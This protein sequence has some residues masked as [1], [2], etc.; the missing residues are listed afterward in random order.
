MDLRKIAASVGNGYE[1][2]ARK[3]GIAL[4]YAHWEGYI[5]FVGEAYVKYV[6]VRK[7]KLELLVEEFLAVEIAGILRNYTTSG[8]DLSSRL[9]LIDEWKKIEHGQFKRFR[10]KGIA[11][12]GNLNF[13][14]FSEIC[15]LIRIDPKSV[16]SD[17]EFLDKNVLGARNKIA[18]GESITVTAAEFADASNFVIEAMRNFRNEAEFCVIQKYYLKQ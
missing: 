16:I 8:G 6:A 9:A 2:A 1:V 11:T 17:T 14:R 15:R 13:Q 18:H 12:G 5:K 4:L 10:E 7:L 3:A